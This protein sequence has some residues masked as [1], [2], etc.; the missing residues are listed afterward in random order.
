MQNHTAPTEVAEVPGARVDHR[1][2]K[3]LEAL[4][5]MIFDQ[6]FS[7]PRQPRSKAYK[8]GVLAVVRLHVLGASVPTEAYDPGALNTMAMNPASR[9]AALAKCDA[10]YA[11]VH[12][13]HR[14]A[15]EAGWYRGTFVGDGE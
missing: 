14:L 8:A 3:D 12:E 1:S 9:E 7:Q 5:R 11:G 2:T 10:F 13:G 15:S 4:A 6:A